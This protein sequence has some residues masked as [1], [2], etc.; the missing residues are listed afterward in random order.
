MTLATFDGLRQ[1]AARRRDPEGGALLEAA[2]RRDDNA[3]PP[4][5]VYVEEREGARER[6]HAELTTL[7]RTAE[8]EGQFRFRSVI[9]ELVEAALDM[10][11]AAPERCLLAVRAEV[12]SADS[13][14]IDVTESR[15]QAEMD[16]R[17]VG[18]WKRRLLARVPAKNV[19]SVKRAPSNASSPATNSYL[20]Q[21]SSDVIERVKELVQKSPLDIEEEISTSRQHH[22]ELLS[23][24]TSWSD[25]LVTAAAQQVMAWVKSHSTS[26]KPLIIVGAAGYGKTSLLA[27]LSQHL[28]APPVVRRFRPQDAVLHRRQ[29]LAALASEV[30][31]ARPGVTLIV[32]ATSLAHLEGEQWR[33]TDDANVLRLS[34]WTRDEVLHRLDGALGRSERVLTREQRDAATARC[35]ANPSALFVTCAAEWAL[36]SCSFHPG[37]SIPEDLECYYRVTFDRLERTLG[38][39]LVAS[40][41]RYV[42]M[43]H[44][45]LTETELCDLLTSTDP[46]A[47]GSGTQAGQWPPADWIALKNQLTSLWTRQW[48]HHRLVLSWRH[49]AAAEYIERRY[50]ADRADRLA[51]HADL[52]NLHLL[53]FLVTPED[54]DGDGKGDEVT[55]PGLRAN[56]RAL[57]SLRMAD[58]L[59]Y[60]LVRS[61][62]V[63]RLK[64]TV[65]CNFRHLWQSARMRGP[66]HLYKMAAA[67]RQWF[68]DWEAELVHHALRKTE[69]LEGD[70]SDQLAPQLLIWLHHA[71]LPDVVWDIALPES[72]HLYAPAADGVHVYVCCGGREFQLWH[73]LSCRSVHTFRGHTGDVTCVYPSPD[74]RH[75]VSGSEDCQVIIW[76]A[77]SFR[78]LFT[79]DRHIASVLCV[80]S[81]SLASRGDIVVSGGEDSCLYVTRLRSTE[82][83]HGS[84]DKTVI[85]WCLES[86]TVL[87][88]IS[89]PAAVTHM[90]VSGG[91]MFLLTAC[92]DMM[93]YVHSF[94]T[95]SPLH[96]LHNHQSQ[97][98][99]L[100]S[101]KDGELCVAGCRDSKVYVYDIASARLLRTLPRHGSAVLAARFASRG[102]L[103]VTAGASRVLVTHVQPL[104]VK[105][106]VYVSDRKK[107]P[108]EHQADI[109]CVDISADETMVVTGSSD[110]HLKVWLA[111]SGDLHATLEGHTGPVTCVQFAPNGL[112]AVSGSQDTSIRVWG[113]TLNLVVA[114]FTDHMTPVVSVCVLSDSKRTLS[115]DKGGVLMLWQVETGVVLL[116]CQGPGELIRVTPDQ[117]YAIS[118]NSAGHQLYVWTL[119]K[120]ETK[121]TISHNDVI[122]CF[123]VSSDSLH[124]I[125]GSN[126]AS[127]KVW[128]IAEGR[129]TQVLVGHEA[130]VTCVAYPA[131]V[132]HT[133]AS[134][135]DDCLV[136]AW[137][138]DT[139]SSNGCLSVRSATSG[140]LET[141][142]TT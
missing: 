66:A 114:A 30:Q 22:A 112:Y 80:S 133:A 68:L 6:G 136:M 21:L 20:R 98:T 119:N 106:R 128:T 48:R 46:G 12:Q 134:G 139:G 34:A 87:N 35:L 88:E 51:R 60:H 8:R 108:V 100:A 131:Y 110:S 39:E 138:V 19:L 42:T 71:S 107:I 63:E 142:D 73:L 52:S 109:T 111:P 4:R 115:A 57:Q 58:G 7:L 76:S 75:V 103:L 67:T 9:E 140:Q 59:W 10:S 50:L 2:Y 102:H 124:V 101:S 23:C 36:S 29:L 129:L 120:N 126:D 127:L 74:G 81:A 38:A 78:S 25:P 79:I 125:T 122:R 5:M 93:V 14:P 47:T 55:G 121:N 40:A 56:Q 92:L 89:V 11:A 15:A 70:W 1:W 69:E 44:L 13:S 95:G 105:P 54:A 141:S 137:D 85:L 90:S 96:S 118:G 62:D 97:V 53:G 123:D 27:Q 135:G 104:T 82:H 132:S 17:C 37:T 28:E 130:A 33:A 26:N 18:E 84:H 77:T 86:L 94:T 72:V 61:G 32:T 43:S 113:L 45:G 116:T 91:A 99:S 65:L 117:T 83:A 49:R 3:C 31:L 16:R 24:L 41:C 64:L